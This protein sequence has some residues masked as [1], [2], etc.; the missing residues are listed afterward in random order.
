MCICS[1][2]EVGSAA[3]S[4]TVSNMEWNTLGKGLSFFM[5]IVPE[6]AEFL[7]ATSFSLQCKDSGNSLLKPRV[8]S[9]C[10]EGALLDTT[11]NFSGCQGV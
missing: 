3:L 1:F 2:V 7:Q 5:Q 10:E 11:E 9:R 4:F 8:K 6:R